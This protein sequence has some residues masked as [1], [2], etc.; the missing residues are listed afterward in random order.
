MRIKVAKFGGTSLADATQF[1]KVQVIIKEDESRRIIVVS[2]PGKRTKQDIKVTDLLIT[3]SDNVNSKEERMKAFEQ[4]ALRFTKLVE[5]LGV[6]PSI[7][8]ELSII[9]K[10]IFNGADIAYVVSRGEYLNGLIM[11]SL[12]QYEFIDAAKVIVFKNGRCDR[13]AS[14]ERIAQYIHGSKGYVIPGFYGADEQ[15]RIKIF[16]RGG[17]DITGAIA[18]EAVHAQIYENW[19]DVPGIFVADPSIVAH[20]R[21][22]EEITYRELR[23]LS[24]MGARV[25]HEDAVLPVKETGIPIFVGS[26][27]APERGGTTIVPELQDKEKLEMDV[28]GIAGKK[29][30]SSILIEKAMMN[31]EVGFGRK[32]LEV[33]EHR[34]ISFE[35]LPSGID[36]ISV[37]VES[38][39]LQGQ[40]QRLI[41]DIVHF[42]QPDRIIIKDHQAMIAIVGR[43]NFYQSG[44]AVRLFGILYKAQIE[45]RMVDQSFDGISMIIGVDEQDYESAVRAIYNGLNN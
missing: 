45:V 38:R 20:P 32:V 43:K 44:V 25:F 31:G 33:L 39:S 24:Y 18:S 5:E 12:L 17:S 40:K 37:V 13:K 26:T 2:A 29:N 19:T 7:S 16:S 23:E 35:H 30:F 14:S 34:G 4:V 3:C 42:V 15:G 6:Y 36:A 11:A 8:D 21:R 10:N 22:I 27:N 41:H 9:K 28:V 1:K